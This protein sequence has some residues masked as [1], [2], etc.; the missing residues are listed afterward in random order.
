[1]D[2]SVSGGP[3]YYLSRGIAENYPRLGG[4]GKVLAVVFAVCCI[5]G[6]IGGGNM[7]QANQTFQQIVNVSGGDASIFAGKG[8]MFGLVMAALVAVV[9]IGGIQSIARVTSKLVPFMAILYVGCGLYI[10]AVDY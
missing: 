6:S 1:A 9:I 5:G 10:L 8:W 7:F 3:M 4:A 2:G